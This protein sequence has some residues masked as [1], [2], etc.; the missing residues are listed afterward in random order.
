[1]D[2]FCRL[3]RAIWSCWKRQERQRPE[4]ID[5]TVAEASVRGRARKDLGAGL[6]EHS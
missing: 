5:W 1:M 2:N 3:L 6:E 4:A